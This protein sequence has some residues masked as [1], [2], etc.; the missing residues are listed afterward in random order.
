MSV[1]NPDGTS[2]ELVFF[3]NGKKVLEKHAEPETT[4]LQYLLGLPG[5]K[6]GCG[7]GGCGACTVMV[8]RYDR[9]AQTVRHFSVNACLAPVCSMH[10]M[11][12]TTVEGIGSVKHG[13]HPVQ[14]R[15]AASHG[16]QCGF[17]TPGIIMSMYTLLRN[18]PQPSIATMEKAFEGNLCRCTGY[19][20]ILDG[21]RTFTKEYCQMGE[22]CCRNK[23]NNQKQEEGTAS[24]LVNGV[25]YVPLDPSQDPIF[26]PELRNTE[27]Y[28]RD[29]LVYRGE[30]V[31]W[32]RPH[33]LAELLD[34]KS[35]FPD[36]KLVIGNT[37]IGIEMKF[38]KMKY[39]VLI[40][41]SHVPELV[42]VEHTE[43][44]I[45]FG[46]SVTLS[47]IDEE[48]KLALEKYPDQ[49]T[50]V[51]T[52]VIEM[53]R[54]FAGYQI[55]NVAAVAGN[56]ITASPI[57]DL[58]PLFL[59]CGA[60]LQVHS[61]ERG[62]REV[63]M[64][65]KFFL[66]Y[67][68]TAVNQD[69]IVLNIT[70]PFTAKTKYFAGYKQAY[71]RE[72]DIATVN[73]G[74]LVEFEDNSNVIKELSLAY[75]GMA[76]TTVMPTRTLT[77]VV[78]RHWDDR[79]VDD[80]CRLLTEEMPL[81]AGSPGGMV[82]YRRSLTLSFFFKFYLTVQQQLQTMHI[83]T[84]KVPSYFQSATTL[85]HKDPSRSS[86]IFQEV[87]P[88]QLQQDPVGRPL[89]HF[90]AAK[91]VAGEAIYIDDIP[92]MHNELYIGFVMS[93][94]AYANIISVDPS[95]A[96]AMPGVVD[97][98]CHKDVPGHNSWG[99]AVQDDEEI[100]A[101]KQVLTQGQIIGAILAE[102]QAQAQ[103]A[104]DSVKVEYEELEPVITIKEA[105]KAGSYH[106]PPNSISCGDVEAGFQQADHVLEGE[107]HM[108][109]QE[110]FYLEDH[111]TLAVPR[112]EDGEMEMFVATQNP[113]ETQHVA[114]E[115]LDIPANRIVVRVKRLGGGFGG[116][117]TRSIVF[118]TPCAIAANKL[119]RPVRVML[120]RDEDMVMS[121]GR[122]PFLARYK[123]MDRALF[124]SDNAYKIPNMKVT[125]YVC[126]T[127]T[128]SNTAFRG[129]GGPQGMM[130]IRELNLYQEG[131]RTHF[132]QELSP[133]FIQKCFDEC[134]KQSDFLRRKT[135]AGSL[136]HIYQDGS[137]LLTHGGVEMGQGLHTKMIQVASR[138]LGI[139]A[140]KIHI[141]ETGTNTVPNTSATAA[142]A[143]SDLNGMAVMN[144]CKTLLER[145]EPV[146][147]DNPKGTWEEWVKAAYF[148]RIGLSTTGFYKTP[149][150]GFDFES[151]KGKPFNYFSYG[152]AC[153][154]VLR[155]DIVFDVGLS[156][157][158]AID[159]GQIEGAFTQGYGLMMME[160]V[161]MSP[162]G[163]M[164]TR[165]PGNYKIPGFG[166][167]PVEFNVTLLKGSVNE[168][169]VY[170]SKAIG[171]PPL[172][173]S[174]SV[175]FAA[176]EAIS[177]A[178][179]DAGLHGNFR[180]D[181]PATPERI[182]MAC[183]DQFTQ[184]FPKPEEGTYTPWFVDL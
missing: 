147:R 128:P 7:E 114:A 138:A 40:N 149:G 41:P 136:V 120:D 66:G 68:R 44:G 71:R 56:I 129:F 3:V 73:A 78:G 131:D 180:L 184:R 88:G 30:R 62:L 108:G 110:H 8:S 67:R 74:M 43:A 163:F 46:G 77:E 127:N 102:T 4:L 172:F 109:G 121:G 32:Y 177:A 61:K 142:S 12:V 23:N 146:M 97:Y 59:A 151:G 75:G 25:D 80:V 168:K 175:F 134:V 96:L 176:K 19:R 161:K 103:R 152:A 130:M 28:D 125:G 53:L 49:Q 45:R 35:Q 38:K 89:G 86:Q 11:A 143:S 139:P 87:A 27:Q 72:D 91:Q 90:S 98:I 174:S 24:R 92:K 162:K 42:K 118:S 70:L 107:S 169:A 64:N 47:R 150:I 112:G 37:E 2:S 164:F 26:P 16:S 155:T 124:H 111:A 178:R 145:L 83:P 9:E 182:R 20:P 100:F 57:S 31:T 99:A 122:H 54:W 84:S 29:Y 51:F 137:V 154:E 65:E 14:E 58:N 156:L 153:S 33:T 158:P 104:A 81:A 116:K 167:I 170:S 132:G 160:Q 117:E 36:A 119:G 79:L 133:C 93:N 21:F 159:I 76:I 85:F 82:E 17:C 13:L 144:A 10:G 141:S 165:G 115:A 69:E 94:K 183:E 48:L 18:N 55:R 106:R 6:L 173:L 5:T 101:S 157:N 15:L 148:R 63:Q 126:K 166:D 135:E 50:R 1:E 95:A 123:V 179:A 39:P 105:I 22:N 34:L 52:A 140:S 60:M 171:E 181:S 113:S